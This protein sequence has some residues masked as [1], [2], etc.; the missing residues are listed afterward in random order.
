MVCKPGGEPPAETVFLHVP[1][2][3]LHPGHGTHD[4]TSGT[5]ERVPG[6]VRRTAT[7]DML[8][9]DGLEGVLV[10]RGAARDLVTHLDGHAEEAATATMRAEVDYT[11]SWALR[12]LDTAPARP[13]L[14]AVLG[15]GAGSGLRGR[16][17]RADPD[18]S[19]T[20][21]GNLLH[22]LLDDIPVT[23]LVSGLAY[24]AGRAHARGGRG[25]RPTGRPL[26]GRDNCAG[27][28]DGGVL[29]AQVD[30]IGIPPLATGPPAGELRTEDELGWHELADLPVHGMRRMR[31]TDVVPGP[32][33]TV[34]VLFRDSHVR[35]D[36]VETVIHE[37]TL[38]ATVDE[39]VVRTLD[40]RPQVL[41]WAECPA[42]AA[43]A[44][45]LQGMPLAGLRSHVRATFAGTSTCTHLNDT[46]RSLED[47]TELLRLM[48]R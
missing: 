26:F 19:A 12:L 16:L 13:A 35:P 7:T 47:V 3:A 43:S 38:T 45:R 24:A 15:E 8:R 40:A 34:D 44:R 22:Q 29:M 20:P 31:R 48:P 21:R 30:R 37:Y 32:V 46:L 25:E 41:P 36:G 11:D 42:A 9:P 6:S 4:P 23:T 2:G 18:L 1:V 14:A 39:G 17:R 27:F 33:T 5:P 28:A 10:L